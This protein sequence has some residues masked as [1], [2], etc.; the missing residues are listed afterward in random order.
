[1]KK[2]LIISVTGM[3]DSLW[4]TP[5]IRALKKFFPEVEI[6][7]LVNRPWKSLFEHNPYLNKI[8]E[9]QEQWYRQ[10]FSGMKL[11]G[12]YYDVVL[13]FHANRNFKRV[14]PWLRSLPVWCHQ[15]FDWISESHC[16]KIDKAVHG[17]QRRRIMLKKFGVESDGGQMEIFFNQ[18]TIDRSQKFLKAHD[19]SS[20]KYI[21]LNLGAAV[22]GR[23]WM[24]GRFV[25]LARLILKTTPWNI[26][27]G[28]GPN[29]KNRALTILN[30][31]NTP[32]AIDVCSQPI[33]VN[34]GIISKAK[35][36]V[37][38]DTGPMHIGFS[39]KT[40]VVALFGTISPV[41]TGPYEIPDHLCRVITIDPE[42][43]NSVDKADCGRF[44]FG[45]ITVEQVWVQV[46]ELLV[47]NSSH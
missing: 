45:S 9:Y 18:V 22:E 41:T 3:G 17:I 47:E 40:P 16:V 20:G 32:R 21:Y 30:Q 39:M 33:L 35:L 11:F 31:L 38:A 46:K 37:T 25:E 10:P 44:Y 8:F 1:M 36:M 6:D 27:L 4:G 42:E 34:A 13:I 2:I 43:G 15:N 26:I 14:L 5:G 19:F 23:R 7:L 24:V 12:R 28:G 29:E